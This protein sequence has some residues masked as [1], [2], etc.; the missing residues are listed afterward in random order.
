M[1]NPDKKNK[2]GLK[3]VSHLFLSSL[4]KK[5]RSPSPRISVSYF[6]GVLGDHKECSFLSSLDIAKK[7]NVQGIRSIVFDFHPSSQRHTDDVGKDP[8]VLTC[9][10]QPFD[11]EE[12]LPHEWNH[13]L[14][15]SD[16]P[17]GA[18]SA[19][20]AVIKNID[21]LVLVLKPSWSVFRNV[22]RL[23]KP[24]YPLLKGDIFVLWEG[25]VSPEQTSAANKWCDYVRG[26]LALKVFPVGKSYHFPDE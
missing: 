23:L 6:L 20:E 25:E 24:I 1:E 16:L 8:S 9:C 26:A 7:L 22:Y 15:L 10:K 21:A 4:D 12:S 2:K 5:E 18:T 11:D 17:W 14:W 19:L 13:L 3:D